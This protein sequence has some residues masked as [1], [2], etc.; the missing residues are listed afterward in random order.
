GLAD[1]TPASQTRLNHPTGVMANSSGLYIADT[2][3]CRVVEIA[4]TS[5][6][7]WGSIS[8]TAGDEYTIAGTTGTC[9]SGGDGGVA[10]SAELSQPTS[11]HFGAGAHAGDV[12]IADTGN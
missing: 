1:G 5:G 2:N 12:Y 10:T 11:I 4:A 6:T 7:Q 8:M 3:D 9:G